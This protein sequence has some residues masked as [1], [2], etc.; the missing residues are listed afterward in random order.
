MPNETNT[1][2]F[3]G[4][5]VETTTQSQPETQ[6][7]PSQSATPGGPVVLSDDALV[8]WEGAKEPVPFK[9]IRGYQSQ[10]TKTS[11][12][13]AKIEKAYQEAV[14]RNQQL[15]QAIG[16]ARSTQPQ[17]Q[18]QP[19]D[20][21][22]KLRT[23]PYLTG[24]E[25]VE[26]VQA[27]TKEIQTRDRILQLMAH[28]LAE[29][30]QGYGNLNR[31]NTNQSFDKKLKKWVEGIGLDAEEDMEDARIFYLAHEWDDED[32]FPELYKAHIDKRNKAEQRRAQ[33]RKEA[34]KMKPFVPGRGGL[35]ATTRQ[36]DFAGKS[37]AEQADELWPLLNSQTGT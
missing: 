3:Q 29:L 16:S 33:A 7:T 18:N 21:F 37:A 5:S 20:P 4:S 1:G 6:S 19:V 30:E 8:T 15:E 2:E 17:S 9:S 32:E 12:K 24:E 10:F 34:A 22:A 28:K 27:I 26:T 13:M 35:T 14:K 25:A 31:T 11:Q 36:V 23:L